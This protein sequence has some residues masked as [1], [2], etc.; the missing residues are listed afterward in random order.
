MLS[1]NFD[2]NLLML[3]LIEGFYSL[4]FCDVEQM[5]NAFIVENMTLDCLDL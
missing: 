2:A 1:Y 3:Y 4:K 5:N